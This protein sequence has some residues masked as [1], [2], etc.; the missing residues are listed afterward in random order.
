MGQLSKV[1]PEPYL[2]QHSYFLVWDVTEKVDQLGT[3]ESCGAP[4][5]WQGC[6]GL[7]VFGMG[8][9]SLSG[10]RRVL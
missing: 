9:P 3:L 6:G 4:N 8:Q 1:T 10:F 5:F 7:A 2:V